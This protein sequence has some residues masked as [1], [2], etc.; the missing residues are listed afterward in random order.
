MKITRR[1]L[2]EMIQ[3]QVDS[4]DIT[5]SKAPVRIEQGYFFLD[6]DMSNQA[7]KSEVEIIDAH[8]E[9]FDMRSFIL[10][11]TL[12][13]EKGYTHVVDGDTPE[14]NGT[15]DEYIALVSQPLDYTSKIQEQSGRRHVEPLSPGR[16]AAARLYDQ[17]RGLDVLGDYAIET[18]QGVGFLLM[19][20]DDPDF[21]V[22]GDLRIP[23]E[24]RELAD[25]IE[26]AVETGAPV[27]PVSLVLEID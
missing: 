5:R 24:L 7:A 18:N 12:L 21:F 8:T 27:G 3:E 4:E 19:S 10:A 23:R 14:N 26:N 25:A 11:L 13:K 16:S 22:N 1:Q 2:R 6:G 15:I 9:P 17:K 20:R